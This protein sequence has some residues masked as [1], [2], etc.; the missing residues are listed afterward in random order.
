MQISQ[1][2]CL[3]T[4]LCHQQ[5]GQ[6]LLQHEKA[7]V[8]VTTETMICAYAGSLAKPGSL[9]VLRHMFMQLVSV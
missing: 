5:L 8:Y 3:Y 4:C 6:R 9:L 2:T 7:A 1:L